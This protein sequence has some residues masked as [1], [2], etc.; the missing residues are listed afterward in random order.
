MFVLFYEDPG[1]GPSPFVAAPDTFPRVFT[2][3]PLAQAKPRAGQ[4]GQQRSSEAMAARRG[5]SLARGHPGNCRSSAKD[6]SPLARSSWGAGEGHHPQPTPVTN[7]K[8]DGPAG[9]SQ[10]QCPWIAAGLQGRVTDII[11]EQPDCS[12]LPTPQTPRLRTAARKSE[13]C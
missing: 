12:T 6:I 7:M 13:I 8:N 5:D 3:S 2:T 11:T 1:F 10:A 4:C 9:F